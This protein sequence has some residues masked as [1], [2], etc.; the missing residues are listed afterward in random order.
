MLITNQTG[1]KDFL[2]TYSLFSPS[3]TGGSRGTELSY[4]PNIIQKVSG[5]GRIQRQPLWL[6]GS[7][8]QPLYSTAAHSLQPIET[9][10]LSAPS[11]PSELFNKFTSDFYLANTRA[12]SVSIL[13]IMQYPT[14]LTTFLFCHTSPSLVTYIPLFFQPQT[15]TLFFSLS[16]H[17]SSETSQ[18]RDFKYYLHNSKY[19]HSW[20]EF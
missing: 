12:P 6:H 8:S 1:F 5:G 4:L 20:P 7:R 14:K 9:G 16:T 19:L 10:L 18:S 11:Y 3:Q 2:N 17:S 13:S 15:W